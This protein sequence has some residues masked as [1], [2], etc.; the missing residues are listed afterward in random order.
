MIESNKYLYNGSK[1]RLYSSKFDEI[2]NTL[3]LYIGLTDYKT[4]IGVNMNKKLSDQLKVDGLREFNDI[5][6]Y[7]PKPIGVGATIE[8][9]DKKFILILRS[10]KVLEEAGKIDNVGGHPE[11]EVMMYYFRRK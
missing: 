9:S 2:R 3:D 6:Y 10:D 1:F 8:T 11:P 5:Y 4:F 7:F